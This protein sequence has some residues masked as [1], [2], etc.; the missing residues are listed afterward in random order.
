[1]ACL[2]KRSL[3]CIRR[4]DYSCYILGR[5]RPLN[6]I[7][8]AVLYAFG[9]FFKKRNIGYDSKDGKDRIFHN[10]SVESFAAIFLPTDKLHINDGGE[11]EKGQIHQG[12]IQG[13]LDECE[14]LWLSADWVILGAL[15]VP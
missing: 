3:R 11:V 2:V 1:M 6:P 9:R 7:S 8:L 5:F 13:G 12:D 4:S 15:W 14:E 10:F